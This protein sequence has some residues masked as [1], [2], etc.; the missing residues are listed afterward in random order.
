MQTS[1]LRVT[2][3]EFVLLVQA[4]PDDRP[5]RL[6]I[7]VTKKFGSAPRRNRVK[8]LV[9]E[10]FRRTTDLVPRGTDFVVI[11]RVERAPDELAGVLAAF[12]RA[13][14]R[15]VER[16]AQSRAEL[17]KHPNKSQTGASTPRTSP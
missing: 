1:G 9:R 4:R 8:R 7:T 10:A 13:R 6:G 16:A 15:L 11:P 5:A 2:L 3:P 12:R 17:A 14:P